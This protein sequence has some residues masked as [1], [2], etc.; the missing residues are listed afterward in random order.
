MSAFFIS[1]KKKMKTL[2]EYWDWFYKKF[3]FTGQ[4]ENLANEY[5][6]TSMGFK[7]EWVNGK[8]E[9]YRPP[10]KWLPLVIILLLGAVIITITYKLTK[11]LRS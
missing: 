6:L 9:I 8:G 1:L 2:S 3:Y 4:M 5:R 7:P 11:L 10:M